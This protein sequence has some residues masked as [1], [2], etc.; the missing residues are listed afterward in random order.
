MLRMDT[1]HMHDWAEKNESK[2]QSKKDN[3]WGAAPRK[4][5]CD[6]FLTNRRVIQ[7]T[8]NVQVS[9]NDLFLFNFKNLELK[10]DSP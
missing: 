2:T 7:F 1:A 4:V 5:H 9:L 8:V 6:S 10:A 3:A